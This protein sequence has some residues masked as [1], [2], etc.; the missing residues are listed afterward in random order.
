MRMT[1]HIN[2]RLL[3]CLLYSLIE[4]LLSCFKLFLFSFQIQL[5]DLQ[6][7]WTSLDQVLQSRREQ[8][9]QLD[10]AFLAFERKLASVFKESFSNSN[11]KLNLVILKYYLIAV[12]FAFSYSLKHGFHKW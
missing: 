1:Y 7:R 2:C 12:Y 9:G 5:R 8:I 11:L 10:A 4:C 6:D 3:H